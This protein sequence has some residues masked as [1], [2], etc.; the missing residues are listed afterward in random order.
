[1]IQVSNMQPQTTRGAEAQTNSLRYL[2]G[3]VVEVRSAAEILATLD[4]NGTLDRLPF[5]P[6]ML[7]FCGRQFRVSARAFKTCVDDGEM[8]RFDDTVL[9]EE[10]RCDGGSHASCDRGCLIFWK[11]AWLKKPGASSIPDVPQA[12]VSTT[13]LASLAMKNGQFFCQSSEILNASQPLP[14]WE[15]RQYLWD[16]KYNRAPLSLAAKSFA[17]AVYNKAAARFRLPS[18]RAVTG[19]ATNGNGQQSLNLK[20]GELVR[21]RPLEQIR[22]TLD[23]EGKNHKMLFAPAMADYCG[24]VMKVRDRVENIVLEATNR[25]RKIKDTVVLEGAVCDGVCHRLCPRKSL[26]FWRECW[27]ERV[28]DN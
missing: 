28:S 26:L 16:L 1:M 8:R 15:P 23:A 27:L 9:L 11:A 4:A 17:I 20:P 24:Q 2:P 19:S 12:S 22:A 18:W 21:V 13:D 7:A 14:W 10:V 25:Q 5:M 6:E 3:E